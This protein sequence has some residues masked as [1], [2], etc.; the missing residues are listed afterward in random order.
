VYVLKSFFFF[1]LKFNIN[2][3]GDQPWLDN[4]HYWDDFFLLKINLKYLLEELE[5]T[6]IEKPAVLKVFYLKSI[7]FV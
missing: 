2:L 7:D 4:G 3:Q 1:R 5:R 6:Y